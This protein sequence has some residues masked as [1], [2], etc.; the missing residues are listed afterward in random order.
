M[1]GYNTCGTVCQESH[2]P[3]SLSSTTRY[4]PALPHQQAQRRQGCEDLEP[5]RAADPR[6]RGSPRS[7]DT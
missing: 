1:D 5:G 3:T 7:A 4:A 6:A 2:K